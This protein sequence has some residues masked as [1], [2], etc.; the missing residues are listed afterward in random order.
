[1]KTLFAII[2]IAV[3]PVVTLAADPRVPISRPSSSSTST[4]S[5]PDELKQTLE[6]AELI[7]KIAALSFAGAF[8][9][10][11]LLAGWLYANLSVAIATKRLVALNAGYD[12]LSVTITLTK[13][14]T[15]SIRLS[16]VSVRVSD[17][18][19]PPCV[20]SIA[21]VHRLRLFHGDRIDWTEDLNSTPI[22][23]SAGEATQFAHSF[24][25]SS[26]SVVRI[27]CAVTG[28]R[29]FWHSFQWRAS[30]VSIPAEK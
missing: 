21:N 22:A 10:W 29:R 6:V 7:L 23:L 20:A 30:A 4:P 16:D 17:C 2:V 24:C 5:P 11:K 28:R 18:V 25:V 27:E 3:V 15:D 14:A 9:C 26:T 13:G 1:M 19:R 12:Y 8:F